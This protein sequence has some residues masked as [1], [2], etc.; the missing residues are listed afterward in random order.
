[1]SYQQPPQQ[2]YGMVDTGP[3]RRPARTLLVLAL[4]SGVLALGLGVAGGITLFRSVVGLADDFQRVDYSEDGS[5]VTFDRIGTYIAYHERTSDAESFSGR[6]RLSIV[7]EDGEPVE[8]EQYAGTM[9]YSAPGHHGTAVFTFRID[10]PGRYAVMAT[11]DL[12]DSG[13]TMVFGQGV[14]AGI[15]TGLLLI[16]GAAVAFAAALIL[17]I[18]GLVK[19]RK[20]PPVHPPPGYYPPAGYQPPPGYHPPPGYPPQGPPAP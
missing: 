4:I 1:M 18:V 10:T 7:G 13:A 6:F 11:T 19:R 16:G 3:A 17:L 20:R 9:T 12:D 5:V 15:G 8:I 14:F 2:P